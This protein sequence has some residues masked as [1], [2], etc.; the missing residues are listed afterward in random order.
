ML[1]DSY[2]E[3]AFAA[4][5]GKDYYLKLV[6]SFL[7][8]IVGGVLFLFIGVIG[9]I[10]C[11]GGIC[12]FFFFSGNRNMEYEYILTNGSVEV[13]AIYNAS[14]R[15]ELASFELENVTMVVPRDSNRISTEKFSK[16]RDYTSRMG[17]GKVISLVVDN[18]GKK[19][20]IL[21][22]PNEKTMAHIKAY[23]RNKIYD[24]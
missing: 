22:E 11:L 20:L 17:E 10:V 3:Q 23:T 12:M 2:T 13:A 9:A 14:N 7:L 1:N 16:K 21:L 8:A 4:K 15:K 19:E 24:L 6:F 5:P 18:D